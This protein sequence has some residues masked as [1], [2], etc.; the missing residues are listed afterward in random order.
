[1]AQLYEFDPETFCA[2]QTDYDENGNAIYYAEYDENG[3]LVKEE[4]Y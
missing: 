3:D 1:M 4:E 2:K